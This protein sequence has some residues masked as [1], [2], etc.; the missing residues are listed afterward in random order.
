MQQ[1]N[2]GSLYISLHAHKND[3]APGR[4]GVWPHPSTGRFAQ[5]PL[6]LIKLYATPIKRTPRRSGG[7][8]AISARV[9]AIA[10]SLPSQEYCHP[11]LML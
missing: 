10:Y 1:L 8:V 9:G 4:I 2:R 3:Q 6:I 5:R 7:P 11:T